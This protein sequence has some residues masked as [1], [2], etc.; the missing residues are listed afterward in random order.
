MT[1]HTDVGAYSMGLL[2]ERDRREFE[3]HLAG[4]PA[5]AAELAELSPMAALFQGVELRGEEPAGGEVTDLAIRTIPP[6]VVELIPESV[7]RENLVMPLAFDGETIWMH[8]ALHSA[9]SSVECIAIDGE[10][11]AGRKSG[12]DLD[13]PAPD[14]R[15]QCP[16]DPLVQCS[17]AGLSQ[18]EQEIPCQIG[19]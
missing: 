7:A 3:D 19:L 14:R 1:A 9:P 13:T 18:V 12:A 15:A 11:P 2:E 8:F 4:C 6:E 16:L 17:V 10:L 5:C